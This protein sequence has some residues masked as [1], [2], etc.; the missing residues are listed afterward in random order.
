MVEIKLVAEEG[1]Q[2]IVIT[3]VFD[4]PRDLVFRTYSDP[5]TLPLWW[6]PKILRT[7][8]DKMDMRTG[9]FWRFVQRDPDGNEYAFHG[10]YHDVLAP[11]LVIY[12]SE[13]ESMRGHVTLE[14][15][16]F[17]KLEG[18]TK[19]VDKVVFQSVQ[20]RDGMLKSGMEAGVRESN[21]RFAELLKTLTS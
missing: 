1:K 14:T 2:E 8:V 20:D 18:R 19:M 12:T 13:F 5:K 17:D 16:T 11:E 6:G 7:T 21:E 10:V 9:G 4:A 3:C 15:V